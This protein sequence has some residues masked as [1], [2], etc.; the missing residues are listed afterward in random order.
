[1]G[2]VTVKEIRALNT[3]A[4]AC[5]IY[6]LAVCVTS[7]DLAL[8]GSSSS[9]PHDLVCTKKERIENC[10]EIG[11]DDKNDVSFICLKYTGNY[12]NHLLKHSR[13][14]SLSSLRMNRYLLTQHFLL[15]Y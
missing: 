15:S 13:L 6:A 7:H 12:M 11:T 4:Q 10:I 9:R 8:R 5:H 2:V 14:C 3:P 1:M